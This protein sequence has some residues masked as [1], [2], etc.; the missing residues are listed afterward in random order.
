MM[1]RLGL[2]K[3]Q[4]IH[5]SAFI[6]LPKAWMDTYELKKGDKVQI[7][8]EE[9]GSLQISHYEVVSDAPKT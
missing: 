3:I 7:L 1:L 4:L 6:N 2:R 5:G 8:L 9:N